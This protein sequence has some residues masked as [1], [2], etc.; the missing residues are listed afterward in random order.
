MRLKPHPEDDGMR[1]WLSDDEVNAL[2]DALGNHDRNSTLRRTAG[3]LGAYA[4]TR[5]QEA[6]A[7]AAVD[8]VSNRTGTTLR[9]WE[10]AAKNNEYRETPIPQQLATEIETLQELTGDLDPNDPVLQRSPKTLNRWVKQAAQTL[11]AESGDEGWLKVTYHDLRRTWGTRLLEQG[12][13]PTVVMS[14]GGWTDWEVFRE[15]Y[16]GEFSPEAIKRERGKVE[17]LGG[18]SGVVNADPQNHLVPV[19]TRHRS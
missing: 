14:W 10:T 8:V 12:V 16:L 2:I 1:V 17:F 19:G 4:G 11:H 9:I 7:V 3:K 6:A 18:D 15:H 5:R 13:L